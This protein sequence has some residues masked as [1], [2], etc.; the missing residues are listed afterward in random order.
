MTD[1]Q[2]D[3]AQNVHAQALATPIRACVLTK[4]RLPSHFLI[5]FVSNLPPKTPNAQST[6]P[7]PPL[8]IKPSLV[9]RIGPWKSS[10]PSS[11]ILASHSAIAHLIGPR[12]RKKEKGGSKWAM[13]VSER[14]KKPW[15]MR[16][17]KSVDKVAVAK[18]WEWDEEMDE[19]VKGLLGR[20][21]VRR[22]RWCVGQEE[23]LVGRVGE[24][25]GEDE[26]V[27][28]IG[29]EGDQ[30]AGFDL[31]EMVDEEALVE[32]RGLFDG[33]DAF[34]LRRHSKTVITHLALE[35]LRNYTE[36]IDT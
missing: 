4:A 16:E 6:P 15:A 5:P 27:V 24:G 22:V 21:V 31:R 13:L 29:G 3:L 8:L 18:E 2:R 12:T 32:L 30:I 20:E 28:R 11:Y 1:F 25:D 34:V 10:Q 33:A 36:E 26:I 17:R 23:D 35:A 7:Q 14:M 9:P 19:R